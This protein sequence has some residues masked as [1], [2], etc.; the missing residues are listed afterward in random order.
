MP[1][2]NVPRP[3]NQAPTSVDQAPE[4]IPQ[5]IRTSGPIQWRTGT[6]GGRH[7]SASSL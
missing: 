1:S 4:M 6:A 7:F 2:P 3:M 5:V